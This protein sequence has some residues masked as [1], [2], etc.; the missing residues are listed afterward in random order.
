MSA[1]REVAEILVSDT[2]GACK[3]PKKLK[4]AVCGNCWGKLPGNLRDGLYLHVADGFLDYY[5]RSITYLK[6]KTGT[7]AKA[8]QLEMER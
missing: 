6:T 7:I 2:C 3:R 4:H 5:D 8:L 1:L